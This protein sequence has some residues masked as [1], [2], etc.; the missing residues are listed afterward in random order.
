MARTAAR[1]GQA[2]DTA[3]K[4]MLG[5]AGEIRELDAQEEQLLELR[6]KKLITPA[7]LEK[8]ATL[9]R[10]ERDRAEQ[11]LSSARSARTA[12]VR[13]G[14]ET[15]SL[16]RLLASLRMR[17]EGSARTTPAAPRSCER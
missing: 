13:A 1:S 7:I 5:I 14:A 10:A 3:E 17:A 9:V 16:K 4:T 2:E 8:R 11:R 12:A 15:A 6:L